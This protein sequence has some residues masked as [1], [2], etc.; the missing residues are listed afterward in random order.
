MS[1]F[2]LV[3]YIEPNYTG[4]TLIK[5]SASRGCQLLGNRLISWSS[6]KQ[7]SMACSTTK[8]EYVSI[9]RCCAQILWI[10]NHLLDYRF[11]HSKSPI[12]WDNSSASIITQNPVQH[13]KTKHIEIRH[14]INRD[15]V[16]KWKTKWMYIPIKNQLVD[17][18]TK[19]L[20]EQ[21]ITFLIDK[22]GMLSMS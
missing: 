2:N 7:S 15:N 18:F 1:E 9:G 21:N 20:D 10:Q 8:A 6:M 17:I 19:P 14:H 11:K 4:H 16:Q 3:G 13:F 12:C 22:L 5:M